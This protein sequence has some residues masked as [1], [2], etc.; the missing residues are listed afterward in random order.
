MANALSAPHLQNED[1]AFAYVEA[2][3]W[4]NGPVCPHCGETER[5]SRMGG[6][7]TRKGL[8]K[9]YQCRK[10]FTVRQGTIFESSH[11]PLNVWLQAVLLIASSKKGISSHQLQ[12]ML[13]VTLKTAWFLSHRIR[14]AMRSGDID[15]FGA[16]GGVVEADETFIGKVDSFPR[17]ARGGV[18]HKMKVLS[19]VDRNSGR[20][21]SVK[22]ERV[23]L[24]DIE[25][26]VAANV[27]REAHLISDEA[28]HYKRLKVTFAKQSRVYHGVGEYAR[29]SIHTNTIEG[30]FSIF[31][32]GMRGIYQHC[33]EK[34]LHRYLAEFDFRYS[35]RI[36]L[37]CDD[38]TRAD[39]ILQGFVGKRLTYQQTGA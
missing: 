18:S 17:H 16:D 1:A 25:P 36:A 2:R 37:G 20:A 34:H 5:V 10:Q 3:L 15:M 11:L 7:A 33:R 12:R 24:A 4:P 31:K 23:S 29:G 27:A 22:I 32:R 21:R 39:R 6:K 14:E 13:G 28:P 19:L 26:I 38:L 35:N 30:F 9:C 8:H